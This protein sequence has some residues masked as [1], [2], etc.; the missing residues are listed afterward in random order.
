V[1]PGYDTASAAALLERLEDIANCG[2]RFTARGTTHAD[3]AEVAPRR[4]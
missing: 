4:A 1:Q 3:V 2:V